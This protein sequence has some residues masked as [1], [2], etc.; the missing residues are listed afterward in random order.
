MCP[1]RET[2]EYDLPTYFLIWAATRKK[3]YGERHS[4]AMLQIS[5]NGALEPVQSI[6]ISVGGIHTKLE[7]FQIMTFKYHN[8]S[9][10]S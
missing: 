10:I 4:Y 9:P 8:G 3:W 6:F 1:Y 7:H 2:S 5:R